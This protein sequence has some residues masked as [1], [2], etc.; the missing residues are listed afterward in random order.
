MPP[1]WVTV[2]AAVWLVLG[3]TLIVVIAVLLR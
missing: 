3:V 1:R 2:G